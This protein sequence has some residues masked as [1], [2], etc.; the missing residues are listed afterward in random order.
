MSVVDNAELVCVPWLLTVI[1]AG[2]A[3]SMMEFESNFENRNNWFGYI[4]S[5][6]SAPYL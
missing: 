4:V 5:G 3:Y 6:H 2:Y 1:S